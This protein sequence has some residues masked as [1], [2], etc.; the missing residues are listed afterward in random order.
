MKCNVGGTEMWVR[1]IA[2][3]ILLIVGFT[4]PMSA[5][6]QVIVFLLAGIALV[7]GIVRYCPINAM[8]GLNTCAGHKH[9]PRGV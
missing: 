7:T 9:E 2:G 4:V 3:V 5:G 1:L 6:W 8:L